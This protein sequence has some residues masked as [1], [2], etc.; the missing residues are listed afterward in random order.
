MDFVAG[1]LIFLGAEKWMP[2][3]KQRESDLGWG[4]D[5]ANIFCD[6]ESLPGDSIRDQTSSPVVGGHWTI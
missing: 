2:L 4:R 5:F 1:C 3:L 6:K